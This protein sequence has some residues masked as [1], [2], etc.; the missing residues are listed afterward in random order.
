MS[1]VWQAKDVAD[2]RAERLGEMEITEMSM[3]TRYELEGIDA[4]RIMRYNKASGTPNSL[5][6]NVRKAGEWSCLHVSED[7]I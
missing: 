3:G 6:I 1:D 5:T 7:K 4:I 2:A